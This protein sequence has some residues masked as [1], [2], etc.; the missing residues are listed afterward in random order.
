M[1]LKSLLQEIDDYFYRIVYTPQKNLTRLK[2]DLEDFKELE[3]RV[4]SRLKAL[5]LIVEG[6]EKEINAKL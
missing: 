1:K 3:A 2:K 5:K 6:K 4:N